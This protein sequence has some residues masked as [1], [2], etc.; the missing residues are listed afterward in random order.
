MISPLIW[1]KTPISVGKRYCEFLWDDSLCFRQSVCSW[2]VCSH[3]TWG[4]RGS[5]YCD[6]DLTSLC[7]NI[8]NSNSH[9]FHRCPEGI[10]G[11][12]YNCGHFPRHHRAYDHTSWFLRVLLS[13][14][15]AVTS[16]GR[17]VGSTRMP[18]ELHTDLLGTRAASEYPAVLLQRPWFTCCPQLS[19][20]PISGA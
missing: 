15:V 2:N 10:P 18:A 8:T 11:R 13:H 20:K 1:W 5:P 19:C 17:G 6:K 7:P 12:H 3:N 14:S 4:E 16:A 9:I